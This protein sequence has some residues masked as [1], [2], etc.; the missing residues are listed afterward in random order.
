MSG[1]D[2]VMQH[3]HQISACL[4]LP[5]HLFLSISLL[6]TATAMHVRE[7]RDKTD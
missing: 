5:Q 6:L 4:P 2:R 3:Y 7:R 1:F